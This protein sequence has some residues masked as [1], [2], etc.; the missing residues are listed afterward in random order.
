[1]KKL[2]LQYVEAAQQ[3]ISWFGWQP[4]YE[5]NVMRKSSCRGF[6]IRE[7]HTPFQKSIYLYNI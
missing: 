2:A 5:W 4:C 1:V 6:V 7:L 3:Q